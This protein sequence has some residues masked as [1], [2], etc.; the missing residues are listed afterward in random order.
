MAWGQPH[1]RLTK[2]AASVTGLSSAATLS[3]FLFGPGA[4]IAEPY[5]LAP[6]TFVSLTVGAKAEL[7]PSSGS[8]R[9]PVPDAKIEAEILS[10][11]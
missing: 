10:L 7:R 3:R 11:R 8:L 1:V 2:E 9:L 4:D 5:L 6:V